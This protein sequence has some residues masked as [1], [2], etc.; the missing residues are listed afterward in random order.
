M[1]YIVSQMKRA[2]PLESFQPTL[3]N[4]KFLNSNRRKLARGEKTNRINLALNFY[5]AQNQQTKGTK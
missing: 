4:S 1:Y 2:T 3:A 5:R